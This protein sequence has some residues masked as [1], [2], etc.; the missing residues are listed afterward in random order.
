MKTPE[1]MDRLCSWAR[2]GLAAKCTS[3]YTSLAIGA[4]SC[5]VGRRILEAKAVPL[6]SLCAG[7]DGE[8]DIPGIRESALAGFDAA[9]SVP[10]LGG[11]VSLDRQDVA[12][13]FATLP[14]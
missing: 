12:D 6:L 3:P 11:L 4:A 14:S 7:P 1:F 9:K 2:T 10:V 13:F 5:G 8:L